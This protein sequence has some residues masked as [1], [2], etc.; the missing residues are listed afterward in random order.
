[1]CRVQEWSRKNTERGG[2]LLVTRGPSPGSVRGVA[3]AEVRLHPV[4]K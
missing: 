2:T 4:E 3:G 1:M